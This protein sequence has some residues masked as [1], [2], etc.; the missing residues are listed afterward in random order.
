MAANKHPGNCLETIITTWGVT[1]ADVELPVG[2]HM[3]DLGRLCSG[4][5]S[6][7][8]VPQCAHQCWSFY[9]LFLW[10][11]DNHNMQDFNVHKNGP[12]LPGNKS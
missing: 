4:T 10:V 12:Q 3:Q 1:S 7:M 2:A 9:F 8:A 5:D 11:H 6:D